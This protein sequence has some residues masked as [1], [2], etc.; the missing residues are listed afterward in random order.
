VTREDII[1]REV[2]AFSAGGAP[3]FWDEL[4]AAGRLRREFT[5]VRWDGRTLHLDISGVA[6]VMPDR[7]LVVLRDRTEQ[8]TLEEQLRQV[9]KME[10]VGR[11]AGGLA[12]DFNNLLSVMRGYAETLSEEFGRDEA[13]ATALRE[14]QRA[15]ERATALTRQLLAF[16]RRQVMQ[17]HVIDL[18]LVVQDTRRLLDR[19]IGEDIRLETD[20]A[21]DLWPVRADAG[22]IG[23]VLLNL[24]VNARDAM[25]EGGRV[26]VRTANVEAGS[27]A[28]LGADGDWI[29]LSVEDTGVGMDA[30]TRGRIF[31]PFF[32]TKEPGAGTGL[33][34]AV[35]YGIVEQSGGRL[36]VSSEPGRG[37]TIRVFLPRAASPPTATTAPAREPASARTAG[38]ETILVA[39]DEPAVAGLVRSILTRSG[40]HVIVAGSMADALREVAAADERV[41]LLLTDVVMPGGSGRELAGR[42]A[43]LHPDVPVLYMSGYPADAVLRHGIEE[44][45]VAFLEKPFTTAALLRSVRA[46]LD[47]APVRSAT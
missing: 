40:Y 43:E 8:R 2:G 4:L 14:I 37:T 47:G 44:S 10:A 16:G 41:D 15:A 30:A 13:A 6:D 17:P 35:V 32:T 12:H 36:A 21:A 34:L 18:N 7:H 28:E 24:A 20:L 3:D 42:L 31:E 39:E 26:R 22:Q 1:G 9:Q 46:A 23:Q 5:W 19:L 29:V 45:R 27:C 38:G 25:P 11:L 33:G